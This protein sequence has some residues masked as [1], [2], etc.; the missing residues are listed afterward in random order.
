[1]KAFVVVFLVGCSTSTGSDGG[2][3]AATDCG[4]RDLIPTTT[5]YQCDASVEDAAGCVG[6]PGA[7]SG[8]AV[9]PAGCQAITTEGSG[10]D[11]RCQRM[12]CGCQPLVCNCLTFGTDPTPTWVCPN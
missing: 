1:V 9:H 8:T 7:H 2:A 11:V 4:W 5:Q 3:D 10:S 6:D 12:Q